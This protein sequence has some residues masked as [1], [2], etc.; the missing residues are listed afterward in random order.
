MLFL[1]YF[2]LCILINPIKKRA[3]PSV[4]S[5]EIKNDHF[6]LLILRIAS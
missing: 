5:C 3:N 1:N 4:E 6:V 2:K